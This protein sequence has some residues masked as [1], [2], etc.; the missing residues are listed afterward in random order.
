MKGRFGKTGH[1]GIRHT[2]KYKGT[3]GAIPEKEKDYQAF[4]FGW[5]TIWAKNLEQAK[6]KLKKEIKK[7]QRERKTTKHPFS[8]TEPLK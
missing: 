7:E 4:Q 2:G 8:N 1:Y 5:G 3:A 6:R